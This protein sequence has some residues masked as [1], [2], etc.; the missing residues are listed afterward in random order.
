[1]KAALAQL[2][3]TRSLSFLPPLTDAKLKAFESKLGVE[4]DDAHRAFLTQVAAGEVETG[5]IPLLSPS[6]A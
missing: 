4:L 2:E 5:G 1:M 6:K 3:A